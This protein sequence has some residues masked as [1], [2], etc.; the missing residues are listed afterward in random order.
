VIWKSKCQIDYECRS[1]IQNWN[2]SLNVCN[3]IL[4]WIKSLKVSNKILNWNES[5]NAKQ[6]FEL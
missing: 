1:K 3:K 6:K 2:E 5:L 4:N